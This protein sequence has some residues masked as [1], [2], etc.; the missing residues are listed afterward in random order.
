MKNPPGEGGLADLSVA[1][2]DMPLDGEGGFRQAFAMKNLLLWYL[3]QAAIFIASY[4]FAVESE[5]NGATPTTGGA[6]VVFGV[7]IAAAYTG[8]ANLVISLIA[9]LRRHYS[10]TGGNGLGLIGTRGGGGK[11]AEHRKRIGVSK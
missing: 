3:P 11:A 1:L 4:W 5:A 2:A 10:Q 7:M 6:K 9:R 8:G